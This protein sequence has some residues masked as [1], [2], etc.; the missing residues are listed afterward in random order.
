MFA[1][2]I[3]HSL[4]DTCCRLQAPLPLTNRFHCR[5]VYDLELSLLC[6]PQLGFLVDFLFLEDRQ[7]RNFVNMRKHKVF[8][9][10]PWLEEPDY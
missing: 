7:W 1:L 3:G 4:L 8:V 9:R 10:S 2:H 6:Q 5:C